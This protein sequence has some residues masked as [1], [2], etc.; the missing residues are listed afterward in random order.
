M[1]CICNFRYAQSRKGGAHF[2]DVKGL[3]RYVQFRDDPDSAALG[4]R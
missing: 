3:L 4:C 2:P 1:K